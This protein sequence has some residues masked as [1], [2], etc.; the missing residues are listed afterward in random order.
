MVELWLH[1]HFRQKKKIGGGL[2]D[3]KT[4]I[5]FIQ[6]RNLALGV[7]M[8]AGISSPSSVQY[9]LFKVLEIMILASDMLLGNI[10]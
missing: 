9:D 7:S 10:K 3:D 1:R 8:T 4:D 6:S 2:I 5:H